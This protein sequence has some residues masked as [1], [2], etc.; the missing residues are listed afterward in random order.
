[1]AAHARRTTLELA[2]R[3]DGYGHVRV[4]IPQE[5]AQESHALLRAFRALR[6]TVTLA[7]LEEEAERIASTRD[8][9][10]TWATEPD[11]R[12]P[13]GDWIVITVLPA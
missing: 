12:D 11:P 9:R 3:H 13:A 8:V 10:L 4:V 6:R 7:E 2:W 1:M 5:L